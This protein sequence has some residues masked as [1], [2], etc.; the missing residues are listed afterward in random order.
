M[1]IAVAADHAGFPLKQPILDFL[2]DAGHEPVDF[3]TMDSSRS[4]TQR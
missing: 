2:R 3:G 4:T 1:R